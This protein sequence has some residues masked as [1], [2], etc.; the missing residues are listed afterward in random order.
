VWPITR[1]W[2]ADWSQSAGVDGKEEAQQNGVPCPILVKAARVM[3]NN[4]TD[5]RNDGRVKIAADAEAFDKFIH[6]AV[7]LE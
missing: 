1:L 6:V 7:S 4:S 3:L 2:A 5:L